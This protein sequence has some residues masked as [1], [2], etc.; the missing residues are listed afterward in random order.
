LDAKSFWPSSMLC[1]EA[2]DVVELSS[3]VAVEENRA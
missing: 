1:C 2:A 3:A